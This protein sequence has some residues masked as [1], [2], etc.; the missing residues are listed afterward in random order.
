MECRYTL[1][2]NTSSSLYKAVLGGLL[3]GRL[4]GFVALL[5]LGRS[6]DAE[7]GSERNGCW[8]LYNQCW[9]PCSATQIGQSNARAGL[10]SKIYNKFPK[11]LDVVDF[12][13]CAT[14]YEDSRPKTGLRKWNNTCGTRNL[15]RT[16]HYH[17]PSFVAHAQSDDSL[18]I[19][20]RLM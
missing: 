2:L 20:G 15:I 19:Q 17:L 12:R 16:T 9:S 11:C 1:D 13:H 8:L 4:D 6:R 7:Q 18:P 10:N 3:A 14:L 5:H